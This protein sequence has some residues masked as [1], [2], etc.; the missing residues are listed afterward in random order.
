MPLRLFAPSDDSSYVLAVSVSEPALVI[1]RQSGTCRVEPATQLESLIGPPQKRAKSIEVK[2]IVGLFTY[3][4]E[5][6]LLVV[7]EVTP[8]TI[9]TE[10][11]AGSAAAI[12]RVVWLPLVSPPPPPE[13][14]QWQPPTS[15]SSAAS[16][17]SSAISGLASAAG[18][19]VASA[20]ESDDAKGSKQRACLKDLLEGGDMFVVDLRGELTHTLQRRAVRRQ[21]HA[22]NWASSGGTGPPPP[23]P[24]PTLADADSRFI[25]N[26]LALAS[27]AEAS[28]SGPWLT[29]IMQARRPSCASRPPHAPHEFLRLLLSSLSPL[30]LSVPV[31]W[32][33]AV[34]GSHDD[35]ADYGAWWRSP[36]LNTHLAPLLGARW[37]ALQD[38]W[39]QRCGRRGQLRRDRAATAHDHA[40][41]ERVRSVRAAAWVCAR[42]L[43]AAGEDGQPKTA[44]APLSSTARGAIRHALLT[45]LASV[46]RGRHDARD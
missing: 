44:Y 1:D 11:G 10:T 35:R 25:W 13:P 21:Q 29:P 38:A 31:A 17:L 39:A 15:A 7:T 28:P 6:G 5:R 40:A 12:S 2:G 4:D 14:S 19:S 33:C 36:H 16:G 26:K 22:A 27:L 43:G 23:P 9:A 41:G 34:T 37:H 30:P 46:P 8:K 18:K 42:I 24:P 20:D 32:W 3:P 45:T